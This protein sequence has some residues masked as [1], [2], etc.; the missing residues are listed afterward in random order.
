MR[1]CS[2]C[3]HL[4][5]DQATQCEQCLRPVDTWEHLL[6]NVV[7]EAKGSCTWD[8]PV[9]GMLSLADHIQ[10]SFLRPL[11]NA[12]KAVMTE[13]AQ[14]EA[15]AQQERDRGL[16]AFTA[17]KEDIDRQMADLTGSFTSFRVEQ[18][19]IIN[20]AA[21]KANRMVQYV[22]GLRSEAMS[23]AAKQSTTFTTPCV[24]L[25]QTA[26][27]RAEQNPNDAGVV[28]FEKSEGHA[29]SAGRMAKRLAE[30][31]KPKNF[32]VPG[33]Q[34]GSAWVA[35]FA[36]A[37]GSLLLV[38]IFS[39]MGL[40]RVS[41]DAFFATFIISYVTIVVCS[42]VFFGL[43][44]SRLLENTL[45]EAYAAEASAVAFSSGVRKDRMP[46]VEAATGN[47]KS[48]RR[49]FETRL[50]DLE[51]RIRVPVLA[52]YQ[53]AMKQAADQRD[54]D[55]EICAR[56]FRPILEQKHELVREFQSGLNVV[57]SGWESDD[58]H[59]WA[60]LQNGAETVRI[61]TLSMTAESVPVLSPDYAAP[62]VIPALLPLCWG[63]SLL[64]TA[65][66]PSRSKAFDVTRSV[67]LRLLA[68]FP[69]GRLRFVL[70]D[71]LGLGQNVASFMELGDHDKD[72]IAGKAWSE[73]SL[74]E[75]Q[76][77]EL[78]NHIETVIQTYL[79]NEHATVQDYNRKA[80]EV[81]EAFRI[82]V[83]FDFPANFSDSA[84]QSLLS[85]AQNGPRCGVFPI[86]LHTGSKEVPYGFKIQDLVQCCTCLEVT[87]TG[88][89]IKVPG[90]DL[91]NLFRRRAGDRTHEAHV[92]EQ[93][94]GGSFLL[95]KLELD[96]DP[97]ES[98]KKLVIS[99]VGMGAKEGAKVEVPFKQLLK[100]AE[101]KEGEWWKDASTGHPNTTA[102]KVEVALGPQGTRIA[103]HLT[104]GEG[105]AHHGLIVGRTGSGKSNLMH[106]IITSLA[107]KYSPDELQL[108]LI[109]FK[110]G[111]EFKCYA[112]HKLPHALTIAIESEREFGLS[113]LR[114]LQGEMQERGDR[115]RNVNCAN[116]TEF[117]EK[118][119]ELLPRI[120][121]I[122]DEFQE[123][124]SEDDAIATQSRGILDQLVR[125]GRY[126][127]IHVL[128][129]SQTLTSRLLPS[130]TLGQIGIRIAL[131][132]S[133]EDARLIMADGNG[134]ARRLSRPGEALYNAQNG[135]I[136]GNELF[137]VALFSEDDRNY[138]VESVVQYA[139]KQLRRKLPEP[140]IF[141]GNQ[142]APLDT[143]SVCAQYSDKRELPYSCALLGAPIEIKDPTEVR[144]R[145]QSG[146][147]LLMVLRDE[148]TAMSLTSSAIISLHSQRQQANFL[149][150]DFAM[151]EMEWSS[152]SPAMVEASSR[153][154][155]FT[156]RELPNQ[157]RILANWIRNPEKA[158]P[159]IYLIVFGLHRARD[160]RIDPDDFNTPAS[161]KEDPGKLFEEILREGPECGVHV[162]VWCDSMVNLGRNLERSAVRE[163]GFRVAGP[164]SS[165]DSSQLIGEENAAK[166]RDNHR[167]LFYDDERP[168]VL[169]KFRPYLLPSAAELRDVLAIAADAAHA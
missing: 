54:S 17:G 127:G 84:A 97:P 19:K 40:F 159:E 42:H 29:R 165:S 119:H 68:T 11:A 16:S 56:E 33:K 8:E 36:A 144:F 64:I 51:K 50:A 133:E 156:R 85:I 106:V 82:P 147:N 110:Q 109:D 21:A 126:S 131:Q 161:K 10:S 43:S 20:E 93:G 45:R 72:L 146:S 34:A 5:R 27:D 73:A 23:W 80:G 57:G 41:L 2:T 103:Q 121:L 164:M 6:G 25:D 75:R 118:T 49:E 122:V 94:L 31:R 139:R 167:A 136:E 154:R 124:F 148:S 44:F 7:P 114:R 117:R 89:R 60:P 105:T 48:A 128:L 65:D 24:G 88:A 53:K 135:L 142:P 18:E 166:L 130:S 87:S 81:A 125:Q 138:Y 143:V 32:F 96:S 69:P 145:R 111:V 134:A 158:P 95:G 162:I 152:L 113:V 35:M 71:P 70:I 3:H 155:R 107:L 74:I 160:L 62:F 123:F 98:L 14:A 86:I 163:F 169:E 140:V 129:G 46:V 66:A 47:Y 37:G 61:G 137:Q 108:Y 83:V 99:G 116:L 39:S 22:T 15:S 151:P 115:F 77:V 9:I 102:K 12:T 13:F 168:G 58:W 101:L 28:P 26:K 38:G 76:L 153:I 112:V 157:L 149:I 55:L 67:M 59:S 1:V 132:C 120:V 79:R 30:K 4:S 91:V 100:M 92:S 150:A 78:T 90:D 141:E 104:F 63:Q 52:Q